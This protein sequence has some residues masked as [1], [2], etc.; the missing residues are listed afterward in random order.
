MDEDSLIFATGKGTRLIWDPKDYTLNLIGGPAA[1]AQEVYA[2][3]PKP[4]GGYYSL[5]KLLVSAYEHKDFTAVLI[6]VAA[7][8][9]APQP[10]RQQYEDALNE[11]YNKVNISWKV[12]LDSAY[13]NTGWD[14]NGD[15]LL[16]MNGSSFFSNALTGEP[17]ALAKGYKSQRPVDNSK[18]Y[19]FLLNASGNNGGDAGRSITGICAGLYMDLSFREAGM[20]RNPLLRRWRMNWGMDNSILNILLAAILHWAEKG[21]RPLIPT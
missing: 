1:D 16:T 10:D 5:G 15:G 8:G 20:A 3:Y 14:A 18:R 19:I 2:L 21:R 11:V 13:T 7:G 4:G 6:P 12:V 9:V 17:A